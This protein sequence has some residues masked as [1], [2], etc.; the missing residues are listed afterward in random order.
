MNPRQAIPE[1][2]E[3]A[4]CAQVGQPDLWFPEQSRTDVAAA[5]KAICARCH[6]RRRCLDY[7]LEIECT[8]AMLHGIW[9]GYTPKDRAQLRQHKRAEPVDHVAV[10]RALAGQ[11]VELT[12]HER[13]EVARRVLAQGDGPTRLRELLRCSSSTARYLCQQAREAAA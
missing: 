7:A 9:G 10:E 11:R 5:A 6:V 4:S 3:Q 2:T 1:W 12:P 8:G 13:V